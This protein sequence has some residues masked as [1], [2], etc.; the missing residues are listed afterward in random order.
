MKLWTVQTADWQSTNPVALILKRGILEAEDG[1]SVAR[2][3]FGLAEVIDI[4]Q[5]CEEHD[6]FEVVC[7]QVQVAWGGDGHDAWAVNDCP[8]ACATSRLG[9]TGVFAACLS[10]DGS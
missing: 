4:C 8:Y 3:P 5:K 2:V 10:R 9:S 7:L 6:S 1:G